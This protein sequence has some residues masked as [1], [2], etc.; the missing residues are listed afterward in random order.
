MQLWMTHDMKAAALTKIVMY[1]R[2]SVLKVVAI[3]GEGVDEWFTE[4]D[5][6]MTGFAT[7]HGCKYIE[8]SG[9]RGWEKI[10]EGLGYSFGWITLRKEV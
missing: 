3:G 6:L 10:A 7:H 9:R 4:A 5:S 1:P 8:A 2:F